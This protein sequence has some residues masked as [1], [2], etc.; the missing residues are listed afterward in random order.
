MVALK[1]LGGQV[2]NSVRIKDSP[3]VAGD[4]ERLVSFTGAP[5]DLSGIRNFFEK[6]TGEF[7]PMRY[8]ILEG[9]DWS[10]DPPTLDS[11]TAPGRVPGSSKASSK[12]SAKTAGAKGAKA[13]PKVAGWHEG[14]L[15]LEEAGCF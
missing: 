5:R 14:F 3:R 9:V 7:S 11:S 1:T 6:G 10:L 8:Q 15:F 4:G 2:K 12:A 13:T